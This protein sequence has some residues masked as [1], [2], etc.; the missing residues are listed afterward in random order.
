MYHF[1]IYMEKKPGYS[2]KK[3]IFSIPYTPGLNYP[4]LTFFKTLV[5]LPWVKLSPFYWCILSLSFGERKLLSYSFRQT[6][7]ISFLVLLN[8]DFYPEAFFFFLKFCELLG[9]QRTIVK[10]YY[11]ITYQCWILVYETSEFFF[12]IRSILNLQGEKLHSIPPVINCRIRYMSLFK[13]SVLIK[14]FLNR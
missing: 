3:R 13:N 9:H 10:Y 1:H 4:G 5:Q 11:K 6:Q 14:V 8:L 2:E 12:T 7:Y